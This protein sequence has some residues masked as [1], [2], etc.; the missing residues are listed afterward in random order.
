MFFA[1]GPA[2]L[3]MQDAWWGSLSSRRGSSPGSVV[4]A[5]ETAEE[6]LCEALAD[7]LAQVSFKV[8]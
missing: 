1:A 6:R 8:N 3:G 4:R 2:K 5:L 7:G